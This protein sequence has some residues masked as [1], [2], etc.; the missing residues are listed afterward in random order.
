MEKALTYRA[1]SPADHEIID[2]METAEWLAKFFLE[3]IYEKR[4]RPDLAV[5]TFNQLFITRAGPLA[6]IPAGNIARL[7]AIRERTLE[8]VR[9][10]ASL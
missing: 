4:P 9:R 1:A 2:E 8:L 5:E 3:N 10:R 6:A 7:D